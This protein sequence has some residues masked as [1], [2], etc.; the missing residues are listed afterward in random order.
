MPGREDFAKV[1]SALLTD[2]RA[3][4]AADLYVGAGLAVPSTAL[5]TVVGHLAM[6]GVWAVRETDNG[7][8]PG[9]G[10]ACLSASLML[11]KHGGALAKTALLAAGM[12]REEP[13]GLYLVGFRDCYASIIRKRENAKAYNRRQREKEARSREGRKRRRNVA[14]TSSPRSPNVTSQSRDV[15]LTENI[16][17]AA[18]PLSAGASS[19]KPERRGWSTA[20]VYPVETPEQRAKA[21]ADIRELA[22]TDP[23]TAFAKA[24]LM[25]FEL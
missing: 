6:V 17:S 12:L 15:L 2:P 3:H 10:T 11:D 14:P 16:G 19:P 22:K 18:P 25:G 21:L 5:A 24:K 20:P 13:T 23:R 7:I 8:L 4:R 1:Q 9:D